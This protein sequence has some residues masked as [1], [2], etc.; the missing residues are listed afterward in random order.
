L[1]CVRCLEW[2]QLRIQLDGFATQIELQGK[3]TADLTP[4]V[5]EDILLALPPYPHCDWDETK[6]CPGKQRVEESNG[7]DNEEPE[8]S[9]DTWNILDNLNVEPKR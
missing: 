4:Y 5:R 3:E 6:E 2:F 8:K 7:Y 1:R 9:T